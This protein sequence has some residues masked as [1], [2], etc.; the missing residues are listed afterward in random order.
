MDIYVVQPGD[1]VDDIAQRY[2]VDV[3]SLIYIN[4]IAYPYALAIGQALLIPT[5]SSQE[6]ISGIVTNGYAYPFIQPDILQETLP[7]LTNLSIFS[8]GF[9][10]E[11]Q[12][13]PP[14][15]SDEWMI[16]RANVAQVS[17]I[18]TLTPFDETGRFNNQL[19]SSVINNEQ[20][21][22]TLIGQLLETM[23]QKGYAGVDVD[24]EYILATDRNTFS[25]FV[26]RLTQE[27]NANG[28]EVSV[29][30]A[31]KTSAD[32]RGLLYEGKDY[33]RLGA[34]ANSVL[35]MTYEWGYTLY[36]A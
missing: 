7:F 5:V 21:V 3:T 27:M 15:L 9:T 14:L 30:L 29:A 16:A 10:N 19:I 4:Q 18:L 36:H 12:L 35:L 20:A 31:P 1:T 2:S 24:F 22:T 8:Y 28:Y 23:E 11:G 17:S 33:A 26:E 13:I 6:N 25:A 32:Q 34:V